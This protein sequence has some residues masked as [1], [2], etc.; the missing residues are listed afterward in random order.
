M[1]YCPGV[2]LAAYKSG[3]KDCGVF[4]PQG[5]Y[6]IVGEDIYKQKLQEHN[7]YTTTI[8]SVAV[9]GLHRDAVWSD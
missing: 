1:A 8:T 5:L 6:Q 4:V 3:M 2:L 7:E 9:L